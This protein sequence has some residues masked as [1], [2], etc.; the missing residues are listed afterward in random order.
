L[1]NPE[2][3]DYL[4]NITVENFVSDRHKR[5]IQPQVMT[6]NF[7][8]EEEDS[9][10]P[11]LIC[12]I[13]QGP[14]N[15][16]C[17][18]PC[19]ETYCRECICRWIQQ[20]T[21]FCPHCRRPIS[22]KDLDKVPRQLQN[23]LDRLRVKC[24]ACGNGNM[25][26]IDFDD[27]IQKVCPKAVISCP[28]ENNKC[29]WKGQRDQ[30]HTHL[31]DCRFLPMKPIISQFIKENSQLKN[32]VNILTYQIGEQH[33]ENQEL[34]N[35]V[36]I[37]TYQI[38]EQHSEN[39]E[40]KNQL[41]LLTNQTKEEQNEHKKL[42]NLLEKEKILLSERTMQLKQ[43]QEEINQK[44]AKIMSQQHENEQ[45]RQ[46]IEVLRTRTERRQRTTLFRHLL[47]CGSARH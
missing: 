40:L 21:S 17:C 38:G 13:C 11:Q 19:G 1:N 30:I 2:F 10:D 39:Q 8:Y 15:D 25:R 31:I 35:Q 45:L 44:K 22:I 18:I 41:N 23:M 32:Q 6:T 33:S 36:N 5:N 9:I 4:R 37:L 7:E 3:H 29:S 34:K 24:L 14:F 27:H 43:L 20:Q 12:N 46:E 47:S 26:Q 42:Q 28:S 16:P